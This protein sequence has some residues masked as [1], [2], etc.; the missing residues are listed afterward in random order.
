MLYLNAD[1]SHWKE[2]FTEV[3]TRWREIKVDGKV[4]LYRE[5]DTPF[6]LKEF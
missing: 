2:W 1:L 6:S 4:A 5:G 3:G